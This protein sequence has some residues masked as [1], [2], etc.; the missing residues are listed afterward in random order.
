MASKQLISSIGRK[1]KHFQIKSLLA[2]STQYSMRVLPATQHVLEITFFKLKNLNLL[3]SANLP[4]NFTV[5]QHFEKSQRL[6]E[7]WFSR[8]ESKKVNF[9]KT[10]FQSWFISLSEIWPSSDVTKLSL[11]FSVPNFTETLQKLFAQKTFSSSATNSW[12][13]NSGILELSSRE[14]AARAPT[15]FKT[16]RA[17]RFL[18]L[19]LL[20][21][22]RVQIGLNLL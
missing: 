8:N 13:L 7:R 19:A 14:H 2:G 3:H 16:Q 1:S 11:K 4:L 20:N 15:H 21:A 18:S 9:L 5:G 6:K 10:S 17:F 22:Q 12:L